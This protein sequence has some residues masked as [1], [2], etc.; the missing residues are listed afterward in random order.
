[1]GCVGRRADSFWDLDIRAWRVRSWPKA[2]RASGPILQRAPVARQQS[3]LANGNSRG[4]RERVRATCGADPAP[5]SPPHE[6]CGR[7]QL[8]N[9][10]GLH[11]RSLAVRP[12]LTATPL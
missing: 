11:D 1:A 8:D 12:P 7:V 10:R 5:L 6:E 3:L 2:P 9:V 4:V